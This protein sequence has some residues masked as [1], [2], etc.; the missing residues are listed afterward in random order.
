[1]HR[2]SAI[3]LHIPPRWCPRRTRPSRLV[4]PSFSYSYPSVRFECLLNY[5]DF[6]SLLLQE[7]IE[8]KQFFQIFSWTT[9]RSRWCEPR[10]QWCTAISLGDPTRSDRS[11][12]RRVGKECR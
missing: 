11:E 9:Q 5:Y 10:A 6:T 2:L 8:R 3:L 7:E 4:P 12:E 1:M